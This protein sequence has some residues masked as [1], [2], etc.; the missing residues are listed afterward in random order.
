MIH[1]TATRFIARAAF[2]T[3]LGA[4][5]LVMSG[6]TRGS[7]ASGGAGG[8]VKGSTTP[9]LTPELRP[10]PSATPPA[11][12]T[13]TNVPTPTPS[14]AEPTA[15]PTPKVPYLE[16]SWA[17]AHESQDS[18]ARAESSRREALGH[19]L[20]RKHQDPEALLQYERALDA[21]ATGSVYY[22]YG[23]SLSNV[24]RLDD[25]IQAYT[26]ALELGYE[27]PEAVNYNTA[28]A[29]SRKREVERAH[30]K[31][32]EAVAAG[33]AAERKLLTDPDLANL[34]AQPD[35]SA[36]YSLLHPTLKALVG[37][38]RTYDDRDMNDFY[39]LCPNNQVVIDRRQSI[40]D[41][42]CEAKEYGTLRQQGH[43]FF[44]DWYVK[45]GHVGRGKKEST[46]NWP[47]VVCQPFS[48]CSKEVTCRTAQMQGKAA[49]PPT[50]LFSDKDLLT[51]GRMAFPTEYNTGDRFYVPA[52][53]P[54]K[55]CAAVAEVAKQYGS[56]A[57]P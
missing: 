40:D 19:E 7:D 42:C 41:S 24:D 48:Q 51:E 36:R 6:C 20:Y 35:W 55:E 10:E 28:C 5:A 16:V 13:A 37:E 53:A 47:V 9:E 2:C 45:C 25:A 57:A 27:H 22:K 43:D 17:R 12:R 52:T 29:L 8:D 49:E 38:F 31:L 54:A 21:A 56:K 39:V 1:D 30:A 14:P 32:T 23:N 50:K 46:E 11:T 18:T 34:R 44:V 15:N 3:A 26:I 4:G 33:Y